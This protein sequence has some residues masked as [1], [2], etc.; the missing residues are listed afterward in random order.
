MTT[1]C[2]NSGFQ[3][4]AVL[5]EV[6]QVKKI[7][8]SPSQQALTLRAAWNKGFSVNLD[9][10]F[11]APHISFG[12]GIV[13]DD[14][15]L[16]IILSGNP[17]FAISGGVKIPI[18][19]HGLL[20]F[21]LTLSIGLETAEVEGKLI[22][23]GGW[24]NPF[25]ISDKLTIDKVALDVGIVY[26]TFLET[27]PNKLGFDGAFLID[28]IAV[29]VVFVVKEIPSSKCIVVPYLGIGVQF[30]TDELLYSK[31]DNL[32]LSNVVDFTNSV[33]RVALPKVTLICLI[34]RTR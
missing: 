12:H 32:T 26:A 8:A 2:F 18:N 11:P 4:Y 27:G 6:T 28:N 30:S 22:C 13:V 9:I 23:E 15:S 24:N 31:I 20:D 21:S 5:G 25:G 33:V 3:V 1:V 17:H 10:F 14:I 7:L 19:H 34:H 16:E 29:N